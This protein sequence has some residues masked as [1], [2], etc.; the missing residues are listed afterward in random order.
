MIIA[1]SADSNS[2]TSNGLNFF[3]LSN[4]I[5]SPSLRLTTAL[6][7]LSLYRSIQATHVFSRNNAEKRSNASVVD[8]WFSRM[9]QTYEGGLTFFC[10]TWLFSSFIIQGSRAFWPIFFVLPKKAWAHGPSVTLGD[11][12]HAHSSW[13]VVS[14]IK[15]RFN[16]PPLY[17]GRS[18]ANRRYSVCDKR[19]IPLIFILNIA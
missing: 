3:S 15:L 11:G 6:R 17:W 19:L 18:L 12:L 2:L 5:A 8:N 10:S 9:G 13:S 16:I 14:W 4:C 7:K 1:L